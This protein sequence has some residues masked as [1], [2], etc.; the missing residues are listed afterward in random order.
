MGLIHGQETNPTMILLDSNDPT[1]DGTRNKPSFNLYPDIPDCVA[2]KLV[3]ASVP[4]SYNVIDGTNNQFLILKTND[5]GLFIKNFYLCTIKPGTYNSVNLIPELE[6]AL[7]TSVSTSGSVVDIS[8]YFTVW[9][10][11]TNSLLTFY[12]PQVGG[13]NV[14]FYIAFTYI[15]GITITGTE[16]RT[17]IN[18]VE[19]ILGF[20]DGSQLFVDAATTT[21]YDNTETAYTTGTYVTS[22]NSISLT[23]ELS[24][25]LHSNLGSDIHGCV[26][27]A[28]NANDLLAA[29]PVNNN[30]QGT[31]DFN[32]ISDD[33]IIFSKRT[34][35]TQPL[36]F[37]WTLGNRTRF[38][39]NGVTETDFLDLKGQGFTLT[40]KFYRVLETS[41][42][43][44]QD[45]GNNTVSAQGQLAGSKQP[46][47]KRLRTEDM[48]KKPPSNGRFNS[49]R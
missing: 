2:L 42:N 46:M 6:S 31:I 23:G 43:Y 22:A 17:S 28:T 7:A 44:S 38:K 30:Y 16:T 29:I 4:F 10:D 21:L 12:A 1:T 3:S 18:S 24:L 15:S 47:N 41:T 8:S 20:T 13:V 25:F 34:I 19:N 26:R 35:G 14:N 49:S 39:A 40:F 48:I 5:T 27:N 9:V 37:Y 33:K 36:K 32:D 45:N 11:T